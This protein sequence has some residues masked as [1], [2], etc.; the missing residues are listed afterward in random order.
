MTQ[1]SNVS[2]P[3]LW[4]AI[5]NNIVKNYVFPKRAGIRQIILGTHVLS[6]LQGLW[7]LQS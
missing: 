6:W 1:S 4:D 3:I 7:V 5:G 2:N